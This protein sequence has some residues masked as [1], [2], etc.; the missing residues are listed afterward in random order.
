MRLRMDTGVGASHTKL[1]DFQNLASDVGFYEWNT[2]L[3]FWTAGPTAAVGQIQTGVDFTVGLARSSGE[4]HVYLNG[5][6]LWS[7]GDGGQAISAPNI[8]NF[9]VDDGFGGESFRGSADWIR[10][11]DDAST[12]GT[13]PVYTS[14]VPEPTSLLTFA[15]LA[16]CFGFGMMR[17]RR[18]QAA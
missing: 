1:I 5:A 6:H 13:E 15:G 16:A 17:L 10:I 8:L 4:I 11:H 2:G 9:F 14:E 7:A 3:D 12:F 18:K